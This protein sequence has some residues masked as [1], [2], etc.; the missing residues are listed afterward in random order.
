MPD[1]TH[2]LAEVVGAISLAT[3]IATGSVLERGAQ[4]T[5]VAVRVG[6]LRG[7][8][9]RQQADLY[10][11][12]LLS[13]LGCTAD[14]HLA[15]LLFGD[16]LQVGATIGPY[17]MGGPPDMLRWALAHLGEHRGLP[18]RARVLGRMLTRAGTMKGA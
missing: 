11:F 12:G 17:V 18:A 8:S 4:S 10:Y 5:L 15:G 2:R 9:E 3:D 7:L 6:A 1:E 16:E 13:M 14:A